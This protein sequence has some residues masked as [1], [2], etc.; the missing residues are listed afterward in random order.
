MVINWYQKLREILKGR[1]NDTKQ[2][3][4]LKNKKPLEGI[5]DTETFSPLS[6]EDGFRIFM[7][8]VAH[9]D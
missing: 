5:D 1:L 2:R 8:L 7:A 9:L 3:L 6:S 4:L